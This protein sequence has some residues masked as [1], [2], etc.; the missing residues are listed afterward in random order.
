MRQ[1][2]D[3]AIGLVC[4]TR[5]ACPLVAATVVKHDET[6]AAIP[7]LL[8][9]G[10]RWGNVMRQVEK[11]P[12]RDVSATRETHSGRR[13]AIVEHR[14]AV[15][16]IPPIALYWRHG[17]DGGCGRIRAALVAENDRPTRRDL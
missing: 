13:G 7:P 3:V 15:L 14:V 16:A 1:D 17:N 2:E 12:Q 11:E 4:P 8:L 9:D 5:C 6:F 10:G